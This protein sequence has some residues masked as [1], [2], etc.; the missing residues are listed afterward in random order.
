M[1]AAPIRFD[2]DQGPGHVAELDREEDELVGAGLKRAAHQLRGSLRQQRND[3]RTRRIIV[4]RLDVT[5]R[6]LFLTV[7]GDDRHIDRSGA[8]AVAIEMTVAVSLAGGRQSEATFNDLDRG[9]AHLEQNRLGLVAPLLALADQ[10][11]LERWLPL[12]GFL[13]KYSHL[14]VLSPPWFSFS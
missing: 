13:S 4:Q 3:Y 14:Q 11:H 7:E 12:I 10:P 5:Q 8:T 6:A 2:L 1:V 9:V